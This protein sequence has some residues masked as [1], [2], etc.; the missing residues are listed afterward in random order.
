M[1][2]VQVDAKTQLEKDKE[3][4]KQLVGKTVTLSPTVAFF[5]EDN[6]QY[7]LNAYNDMEG[8]TIEFNQTKVVIKEGWK[9]EPTLRNIRK[10]ELRVYDNGEDVTQK[11]G[12]PAA[13]MSRKGSPIVTGATIPQFND[14]DQRDVKLKGILDNITESD[15]IKKIEGSNLPFEVLQRLLE[16][17][18]AGENPSFR[19]RRNIVDTIQALIKS[20]VTP[21]SE[22]VAKKLDDS[23][24]SVTTSKK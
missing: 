16:L 22:L 4:A 15:I 17:E 13:P 10:G 3:L 23:E 12:G 7:V 6:G 20:K 9:L 11:F 21:D 1:T 24:E 18:L 14:K 19:S 8:Q 5:V 2:Q